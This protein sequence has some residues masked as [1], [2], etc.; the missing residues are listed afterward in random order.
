[1]LRSLGGAFISS[2]QLTSSI[3]DNKSSSRSVNARRTN[4][5]S[6]DDAKPQPKLTFPLSAAKTIIHY[7]DYLSEY[8]KSEILSYM[9]IYYINK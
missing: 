1:M 6:G 5:S 4:G 3:K 8:E 9:V 2:P 7:G